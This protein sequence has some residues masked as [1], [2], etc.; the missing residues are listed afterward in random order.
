[1]NIR[2]ILIVEDAAL[3]H[4]LY[5]LLLYAYKRAGT[6]LAF[7]RN[8]REAL[9]TLAQAPDVDLIL[10]DVNM[11]VMS[12]LEFLEHR[13]RHGVFERIPVIIVTTEGKEEDTVRGLEAGAA[14]YLK[15]P[16]E[17]ADL[18]HIIGRVF[19][20][21]D[22]AAPPRAAAGSADEQAPNAGT[23]PTR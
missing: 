10:L 18:H 20:P 23:Q 2:K 8:G 5:D 7:A 14:A 13:R 1:M 11:P 6:K 12:G 19:A 22:A 3:L 9:D 15:K 17:A 21:A 4:R 16:F